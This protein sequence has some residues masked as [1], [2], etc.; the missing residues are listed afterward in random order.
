M[1]MIMTTTVIIMIIT[2]VT[3]IFMNLVLDPLLRNA[4]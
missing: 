3:Y 1:M 2:R 4:R